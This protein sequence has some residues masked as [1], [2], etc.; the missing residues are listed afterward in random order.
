MDMGGSEYLDVAS[1]ADYLKTLG[2]VDPDR[3]GVWGLSY[4]GFMTLQAAWKTPTLFRCLIDVA[5]VTDW[6]TFSAT[7]SAPSR[8]GT[9]MENPDGFYRMAPWKHMADLSRPL[10]IMQGTNDTNVPFRESLQLVDELV[11]LGKEF[12]F[13]AYPG[14]IHF[15]RRAHVLRDAWR[16]AEEFFDEHLKR[17]TRVISSN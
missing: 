16:R 3:I 9:P 17:G 6:Y 14:E 15:F 2:Y 4:G 1:G 13:V 10:L 11:K 5:G 12:Q 8:M 7:N